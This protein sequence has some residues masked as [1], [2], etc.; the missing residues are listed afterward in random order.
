MRKVFVFILLN[1][2]IFLFSCKVETLHVGNYATQPG[3]PVVINK[4]K[5]IY[6]FWDKVP[7]QRVEKKVAITDYEKI[8][9]RN[10]F[11]NVIYYGTIGIFSFYTVK[12]NAKEPVEQ[13]A[14]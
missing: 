1:V 11:D 7:L 10:L 2:T 4:G 14:E 6:L 13:K 3:K 8:V 5:D 12:I 9:K